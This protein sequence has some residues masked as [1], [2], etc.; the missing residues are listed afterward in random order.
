[1]RSHAIRASIEEEHV[2]DDTLLRSEITWVTDP[3]SLLPG[4]DPTSVEIH[5]AVHWVQVYGELIG[6]TSALLERSEPTVLGMQQD[7]ATEA[8]GTQQVLRAQRLQYQARYEF[9]RDRA[10]ALSPHSG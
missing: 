2:L 1:V 8:G 5:V 7:A 3:E 6:M 4:E 10:S 9:W